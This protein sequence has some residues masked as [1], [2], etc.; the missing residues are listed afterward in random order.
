MVKAA[1]YFPENIYNFFG[2]A[3]RIKTNSQTIATHLQSSYHRYYQGNATPPTDHANQ[4]IET[5]KNLIEITDD[6]QASNEIL[7]NSQPDNYTLKCKSI[8]DFEDEYYATVPDPLSFIQWIVLK[9]IC[10]LAKDYQMI[11][12]GAV[13][14]NDASIIFP[15]FSGMG[16]TTLTLKL[17]QNG[18]KFLSDELACLQPEK[19]HVEPFYRKININDK[20]R[21]LL[22][23]PQFPDVDS[24]KT[25]NGEPEWS[26]DIEDIVPSCLSGPAT[27][28][29]IVFLQGFGE[30]PRLE[31]I[32]PSFALFKI[33]KFSFSPLGDRAELL[34]NYAPLINNAR[35]YN[36][37]AGDLDETAHLIGRIFQNPDGIRDAS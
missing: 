1:E 35:C 7:I 31:A 29:C 11:H 17:V 37:I 20:S 21:R 8:Y 28:R 26:I 19:F 34:Y 36:L 24:R 10:F 5:S 16:K 25:E 33:F 15:S 14:L 18:F 30:K 4:S 2:H 13:S 23:L 22:Q 12:A 3:I 27:L 9:N 32:S 6:I